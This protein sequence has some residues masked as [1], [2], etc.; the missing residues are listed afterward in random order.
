[1]GL[2]DLCWTPQSWL[3]VTAAT[4]EGMN[5]M[6]LHAH[7]PSASDL[8]TLT[9]SPAAR[10]ARGTAYRIW[11]GPDGDPTWA[12]P[13]LLGLLAL[14]AVFYLWNLTASGYANSFYSA[15]AQAGSESWKAFFYG[16]SDAANSITVDKPPASLWFMALSVRIFGLSSF[17]ILLPEVL[18]GIAT[19][20]V[21][22]AT[23]KRQFGAA[24]GLLAGAI[25]ALTPVA[26]LMFRFNNPDAL[27]VLA[28][29]L[30][31]WA[32]MR[33][34]EQSSPKWFA[35]VGVFIGLAFLTKT[36]QA[37]L[38]VPG[39]ALAY[40]I[41][42]NIPL[43]QRIWH[44]ILGGLAIVASAGWWVAIVE[45]VPESARP[46]IG[47]SQT[48][49][50]LELTFGYNGLGRINGNETGSVGGG[51]GGNGGNWGSTGL[52]RMFNADNGGQ[53][54]WLMP[55]ALILLL[56]GLVWR[57]RHPRTDAR[58][59][60]YLA[61]GSW[62][63]V[64]TLTSPRRCSLPRGGASCCCRAR[65]PGTAGC[66]SPSSPSASRPPRAWSCSTGST[67]KPSQRSSVWRSPPAC[68]APRHTACRRS[69]PAT[70]GPSSRPA[71][72][73]PGK[74]V[75]KVCRVGSPPRPATPRNPE[76]CRRWTTARYAGWARHDARR[77]HDA[78]CNDARR[79]DGWPRRWRAGRN[80]RAAQCRPAD[81]RGGPGAE[82][83]RRLLHLGRRRRG[84]PAG[85]RP[86]TGHRVAG[87]G[88]RRGQ[89][90]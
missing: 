24:A 84:F 14:T 16:S 60:A 30:A 41:A 23:V 4:L 26:V 86:A 68:S 44:T 79:N 10:K 9:E 69:R 52:L 29:T 76:R 62:F 89:R 75:R 39:F 46:Y 57:A 28:M 83:R 18:M 13:A 35:L 11:R 77:H 33:S 82:H 87:H 72:R 25:L 45:L 36:L 37:F 2:T 7:A 59:A 38:V 6:A 27:L 63:V 19:V 78:R 81:D 74:A 80:G 73:S 56:A 17:A 12:R 47:G 22:Y 70:R 55:T 40:L 5:E 65:S 15:A 85:R 51:G 31:A 3:T 54:S 1:M 42:A 58:R 66:A 49:S 53:I 90:L 50:F 43:L 8:P 32:T 71:P 20:G 64:T 67:P 21:L 48:N 34:I 88:H 61:W